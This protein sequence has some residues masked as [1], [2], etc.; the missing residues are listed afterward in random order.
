M[1]FGAEE[2]KRHRATDQRSSD[3]LEKTGKNPHYH[4]QD[5]TALPVMGKILWQ[6]NRHVTVFKMARQ[7]R[8]TH[9]ADKADWRG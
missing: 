3:V 2:L 7:Q 9:P 6:R 8:E 5:E 4:Q 1:H